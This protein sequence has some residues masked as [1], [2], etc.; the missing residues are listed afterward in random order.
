MG[1]FQRISRYFRALFG[2]AMSSIEDPELIL[3]QT[4]DDMRAKI[5]RMN[6]GLTKMRAGATLLEEEL[7]Q[8]E[9]D[10]RK[11]KSTIRAAL[12]QGD[13][14]VAAGY[15]VRLRDL[16]A[17]Y[18]RT[19]AQ[20][21]QAVKAY[22]QANELRKEYKKEIERKTR[23]FEQAVDAKRIAEFKKEVASAFE[24]FQVGDVD[25]T[26]KEMMDK[27]RRKT[28]EAEA[29]LDVAMDHLDVEQYKLQRRA[30]ELEAKE[31]LNQ[32]KVEWGFETETA[33]RPEKTLGTVEPDKEAQ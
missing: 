31:I 15:A 27:M 9:T 21:E 30:E 20:L 13:E 29:R 22:E 26:Y 14:T 6:E 25:Y 10:S 7:K 3:R 12:E 5:P 11:L 19:R 23:E 18:E 33:P 8:Y 32:F 17:G 24:T 2:G 28:A 16:Q 4:I 1:F